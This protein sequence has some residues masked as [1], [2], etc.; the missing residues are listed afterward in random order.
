M[1]TSAAGHNELRIMIIT[2]NKLSKRIGIGVRGEVGD[3]V[4]VWGEVN[5]GIRLSHDSRH[6]A[7]TTGHALTFFFLMFFLFLGRLF[8]KQ[9]RLSRII[10]RWQSAFALREC[11]W[12][13]PNPLTLNL[14]VD[15]F[16]HNTDDSF[17]EK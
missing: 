2:I 1:T 4:G 14:T 7:V 16:L 3:R 15:F 8:K 13:N 17:K 10:A 12:L 6:L 5:T 11:D 9:A